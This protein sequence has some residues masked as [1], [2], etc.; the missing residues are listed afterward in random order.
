MQLAHRAFRPEAKDGPLRRWLQ[1]RGWKKETA[2]LLSPRAVSHPRIRFITDD[3]MEPRSDLVQMDALRAANILN[4]SYFSPEQLRRMFANLRSRVK[5]GG[6]VLVCRTDDTETNHAAL[7]RC[8]SGGVTVM[9]RLG[10]GSAMEKYV[11]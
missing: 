6:L 3:I 10:S 4:E 9:D 2:F 11:Q 8:S 7:F 1:D 5:E